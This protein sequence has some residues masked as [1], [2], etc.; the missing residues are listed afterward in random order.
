MR[1][2]SRNFRASPQCTITFSARGFQS[3]AES[4]YLK[5]Q[6]RRF[7]K[8]PMMPYSKRSDRMSSTD[9][10]LDDIQDETSGCEVS[11]LASSRVVTTPELICAMAWNAWRQTGRKD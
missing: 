1:R 11:C 6:T 4:L 8:E 9:L 10:L 5:D 7:V 3:S 2:T